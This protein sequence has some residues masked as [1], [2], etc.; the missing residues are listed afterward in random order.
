[1]KR[2]I[3]F[4]LICFF[5][6]GL[7]GCMS[8]RENLEL[9]EADMIRLRSGLDGAEVD[10]TDQEDIRRITENINVL[11]FEKGYSSKDYDGWSYSLTW[12][13]S[14]GKA[15]DSLTVMTGNR[16]SYHDFFYVSVGGGIDTPF[17][18]QLLGES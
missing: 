12:Y 17:F 14:Q 11:K 16:V 6:L 3:A 13:D 10:I 2:G 15:L 1:M 7:A 4:I 8:E 9:P 18:D 5:L